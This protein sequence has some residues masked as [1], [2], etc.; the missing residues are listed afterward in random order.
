VIHAVLEYGAKYHT[1]TED[2]GK[3]RKDLKKEI[4]TSFRYS[5]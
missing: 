5:C 2:E 3:P 1:T 4:G